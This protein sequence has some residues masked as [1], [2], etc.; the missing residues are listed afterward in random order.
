[1]G[2]IMYSRVGHLGIWLQNIDRTW[3]ETT[4]KDGRDIKS[5]EG[6]EATKMVKMLNWPLE[7]PTKIA[8]RLIVEPPC[9]RVRGVKRFVIL[10]NDGN[11]SPPE[12]IAMI[13]PQPDRTVQLQ[14]TQDQQDFG[15]CSNVRGRAAYI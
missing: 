12:L 3:K 2:R 13:L 6:S 4:H 7:C 5:Q 1:M 14:I 10:G 8:K 11:L 9:Q 15:H